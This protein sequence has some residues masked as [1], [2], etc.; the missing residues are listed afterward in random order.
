MTEHEL[1]MNLI[2][3]VCELKERH[4]KD[5]QIMF[6]KNI[7]GMTDEQIKNYEVIR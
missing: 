3:Y 4:D 2:E 1:F 5:E 7:I 6:W